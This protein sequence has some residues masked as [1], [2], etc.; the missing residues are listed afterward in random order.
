MAEV[1][2]ALPD[3]DAAVAPLEDGAP[4]PDAPVPAPEDPPADGQDMAPE[5]EIGGAMQLDA[6]DETTPEI[7]GL[8]PGPVPDAADGTDR[9]VPAPEDPAGMSWPDAAWGAPGD[10]PEW[11]QPPFPD[12]GRGLDGAVS[13]ADGIS[14]SAEGLTANPEDLPGGAEVPAYGSYA[15]VN[16]LMRLYG[17]DVPLRTQGWINEKLVSLR[18][19]DGRCSD[20]RYRTR[21]GGRCSEKIFDCVNAL[22]EKACAETEAA[23]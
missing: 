6:G 5:Q 11:E 10:I 3:A 20:L 2:A 19:A 8:E 21:K 1:A 17:V 14:L 12:P 22:I 13:E 7:L 18:I 9:D 16:H 4:N 23:A 15:I